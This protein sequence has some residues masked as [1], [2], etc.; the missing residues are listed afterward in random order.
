MKP[1][2]APL[3]ESTTTFGLVVLIAVVS[4]RAAVDAAVVP[5]RT[6]RIASYNNPALSYESGV[7]AGAGR[8]TAHF[9]V[10]FLS[11]RDKSPAR[12]KPGRNW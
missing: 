10:M 12:L 8:R 9:G 5:A 1:W 11:L 7:D 6:R 3:R 4:I 2:A